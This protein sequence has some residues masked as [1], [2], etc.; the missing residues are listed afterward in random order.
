MILHGPM[1]EYIKIDELKSQL[2]CQQKSSIKLSAEVS[3]PMSYKLNNSG[4]A[5]SSARS[6]LFQ[7]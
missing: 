3:I 7:Q 2:K 5:F 6:I 1:Q 4:M